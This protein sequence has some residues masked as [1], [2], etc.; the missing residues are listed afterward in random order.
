[1]A[2]SFAPPVVPGG[3]VGSSLLARA[4]RSNAGFTVELREILLRAAF[5]PRTVTLRQLRV[6]AAL[7]PIGPFYTAWYPSSGLPS[8]VRPAA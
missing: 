8:K 5:E 6:Q 3:Q 7:A 2:C 1:M 4:P